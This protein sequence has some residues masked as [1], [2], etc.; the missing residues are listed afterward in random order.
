MKIIR[1]IK[2]INSFNTSVITLGSYDGLHIGHLKILKKTISQSRTFKCPSLLITYE[3]HPKKV[4]DPNTKEGFLLS[5][6][7]EKMKII[8][9]IGIDYVFIISFDK[10]F[11]KLSAEDFMGKIIKKSINPTAIVVGQM[12]GQCVNP[13][14]MSVHWSIRSSRVKGDPW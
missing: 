6:F 2:G 10:K 11:S 4:L 3:P 7:E 14:K 9:Q 5:S 12:S 1:A 13:K 8:E